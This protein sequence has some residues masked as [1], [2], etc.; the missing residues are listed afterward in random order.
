MA[1]LTDTVLANSG[2]AL[3]P[4]LQRDLRLRP[5]IK[6]ALLQLRRLQTKTTSPP[7]GGELPQPRELVSADG[8]LD[9]HLTFGFANI[10]TPAGVLQVRCFQLDGVPQVLGA[11]LRPRPGNVLDATRLRNRR[12]RRPRCGCGRAMC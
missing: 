3:E 6:S 11:P 8:A 12:C 2:D 10:S 9:V 5:A 1:Q 7:R 4:P